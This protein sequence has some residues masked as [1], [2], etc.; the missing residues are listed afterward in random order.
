MQSSKLTRSSLLRLLNE[1]NRAILTSLLLRIDIREVVN[2]QVHLEFWRV[3]IL[4]CLR[5]AREV[6]GTGLVAVRSC[7]TRERERL[8]Q[9]RR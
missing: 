8:L 4:S 5:V 6:Q 9:V 7:S 2:Y 1:M 3:E